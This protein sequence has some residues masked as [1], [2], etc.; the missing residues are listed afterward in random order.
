MAIVDDNTMIAFRQFR[1]IS[2]MADPETY[3]TTSSK[4]M[5][6]ILRKLNMESKIDLFRKEK[7]SANIVYH[8]LI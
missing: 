4:Q 7:I 3:E 8:Q 1:K 5:A 2:K 6:S